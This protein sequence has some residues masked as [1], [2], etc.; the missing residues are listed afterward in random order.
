M[1]RVARLDGKAIIVTGAARGIGRGIAAAC[2]A[3]KAK[4]LLVDID[5]AV[6]AVAKHLGAEALVADVT[7]SQSADDA[8]AMMMDRFGRL[9]GLVNNAGRVDEADILETNDTLWDA[10]MALN[11]AAPFR[12]SR[13]VIP[14]MLEAG[15]GSIVNISSIEAMHVRPRH[16]PYVVSKSGLNCLTRAIAVDF[17]RQGVRCNTISPG[18]VRTEMFETYVAQYPGLEDRLLNLNYAGRLG[19]PEEIGQAAVYLLSDET[20]FLSGHDLVIDGARTV[21]T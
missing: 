3:E 19:T 21:A 9:D 8:V 17:G 5:P 14:Q 15:G 16:F 18:S 20:R 6:T 7:A 11:L 12:W 1:T 4:V 2:L 13:T 10:T